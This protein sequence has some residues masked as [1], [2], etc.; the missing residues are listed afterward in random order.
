MKMSVLFYIR[1]DIDLLILSFRPLFHPIN[2]LKSTCIIF[3]KEPG[4]LSFS[5]LRFGDLDWLSGRKLWSV[6]LVSSKAQTPD[7]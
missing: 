1:L 5:V 6:Q 2:D 3:S 4:E 7:Y